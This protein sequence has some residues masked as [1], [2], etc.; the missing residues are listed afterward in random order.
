MFKALE[1][2][3]RR[4]TPGNRL[5][6]S[7]VAAQKTQQLSNQVSSS[8]MPPRTA[9][10]YGQTCRPVDTGFDPQFAKLFHE[11][12][13]AVT[14]AHL[15]PNR[16]FEKRRWTQENEREVTTRADDTS[17]V[18]S[19]MGG[20]RQTAK[21]ADRHAATRRTANTNLFPVAGR[22]RQS[23][24]QTMRRQVLQSTMTH[25]APIDQ[26]SVGRAAML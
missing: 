17:F 4:Y 3:R 9:L 25:N 19:R 26:R 21:T 5:G 1:S 7:F 24:S 11:T 14:Q 12:S 23:T 20:G 16:Y 2:Y 22:E 8:R 13:N 18:A 10:G 15:T 6:H